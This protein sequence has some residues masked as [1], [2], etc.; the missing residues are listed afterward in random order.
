M[1]R[2][3]HFQPDDLLF[4]NRRPSSGWERRFVV[5]LHRKDL[6]RV[7]IAALAAEMRLPF[8]GKTPA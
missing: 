5:Y 6:R 3:G 2:T 1:W 8:T 4:F 7:G